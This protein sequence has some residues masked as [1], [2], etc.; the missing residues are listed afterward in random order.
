M[1]V[2]LVQGTYSYI[3]LEVLGNIQLTPS[4]ETGLITKG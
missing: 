3:T 4:E 2:L 1:Q